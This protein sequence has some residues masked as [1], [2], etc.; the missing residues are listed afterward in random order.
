MRHIIKTGQNLRQLVVHKMKRQIKIDEE[1]IRREFA[2]LS[3]I[4]SVSFAERK[5]A[6]RLVQKL[7]EI[8]FEVWED[9]AGKYYGGNAGNLY[10]FLKGSLPGA[11]I[12]LSAHMDTVQPGIGKKAV[13]LED[14]RIVSEKDTI[15]GA[16]DLTGIIEILEGIRSVRRAGILHRDIE[17]LF[18]IAEEVY[19]KGSNLFDFDKIKAKEAYVL[20]MKGKVG[21][22]ALQAPSLISFQVAIYGK[23]AHAGFEPENG[24]HAISVMS[25]V[26]GSLKQGHVDKDTTFNIGTITG[27]TAINIV[28]DFCECAG[29]VRSFNHKRALQ[30]I[31]DVERAFQRAAAE[32]GA[33]VCIK[34]NVDLF[35]YQIEKTDPVVKRLERALAQMGIEPVLTTTFGGSDNNNFVKHGI[36]GIVL[37]CGMFEV[38]STQEYTTI[39]EIMLGAELV[40]RLVS[41]ENGTGIREER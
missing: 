4:D 29:E 22:A 27:G 20:D 30:C 26:L 25:K 34:S 17:I 2:E 14:G 32:A 28:P 36:H 6:D 3:S 39:G 40:A 1:S 31:K 10:G 37:S 41:D 9:N 21:A 33:K 24:V 16:D 23:S 8:G 13:F 19:I 11:P 12:L 15:L 38:H 18:P 7:T 35:A 5:M